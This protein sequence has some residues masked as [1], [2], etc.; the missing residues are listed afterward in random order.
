[1]VQEAWATDLFSREVRQFTVSPV[2]SADSPFGRRNLNVFYQFADQLRARP[3]RIH[4]LVAHLNKLH[5][6][7]DKFAD[8]A[9]RLAVSHQKLH[10]VSLRG[11][12]YKEH[13]VARAQADSERKRRSEFRVL[14]AEGRARR[15]ALRNEI[16]YAKAREQHIRHTFLADHGLL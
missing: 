9:R 3:P 13:R 1:M 11:Q 12:F 14:W 16:K 8:V 10:L 4:R 15:D 7:R 2:F 6:F 5:A